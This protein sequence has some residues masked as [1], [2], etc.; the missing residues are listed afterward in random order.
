MRQ[1]RR[2][3]ARSPRDRAI[4]R[5]RWLAGTFHLVAY[6]LM[7]SAVWGAPVRLVLLSSRV[8]AAARGDPWQL[9]ALFEWSLVSLAASYLLWS[10]ADWL[11][12][13]VPPDG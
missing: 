10:A 6:V 5:A 2:G 3:R 12:D 9:W 1:L 4:R 7:L 13:V 11:Q 8:P